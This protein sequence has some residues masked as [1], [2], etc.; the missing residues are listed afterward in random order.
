MKLIGESTKHMSS[1]VRKLS[2]MTDEAVFEE[3]A[4][5]ILREAKPEY[6]G[7]LHPGVNSTGKTVKSP[8]DGISFV[9]GATPSHMVAVHHTTCKR[10]GLQKKWLFDPATVTVRKGRRR[11]PTTPPGD[12]IKTAEIVDAERER[13]ATLLATLVLTTN[14]EPPEDVV[15]DAQAAGRLRGIEVDVWSVSRLAHFLDTTAKGQW[16]RDQYLGIAQE[17]LS[18]EL[19]AKLS[20]ESLEIHRPSDNPDAW[21]STVL[22]GRIA[23][24]LRKQEAVFIT[25]ESGLG[26][27][28][29]C[30]KR[31][32][33]HV[34][35]G[36]FGL[37]I[38]HQVINAALTI[39]QAVEA[40]LIQLH[41]KLAA[42]AGLDALSF[43]SAQQPLV[44]VIEDINRSGQGSL[45]L[46][47]LA[48]WAV[49]KAAATSGGPSTGG[50]DRDRWRLL[51]PI[52]PDVLASLGDTPRKHIQTLAAEGSVLTVPEGRE[53]VQRRGRLR[54][55]L[56]S[57]LD[58]DAVS[59]ALGHD[60]LLIALHE[61]TEQANPE[62]VIEQFIDS[63]VARS[64][65]KTG[66]YTAGEYRE[67]L[68]LIASGMLL[69]RT[70]QPSWSVLLRW[71]TGHKGAIPM[72]RQLVR[73]GEIIRIS[74][75]ASAESL[76]FRHDRVRDAL[77]SEAIAS[78][79]RS[80]T[81]T[82]D[83]LGEVYFAEV[84]GAAL[85]YKDIPE[86]VVDR[87]RQANPLALFH[88]LRLFRE[89][90]GA[91]HSAVLTA[92]ELWLSDPRTHDGQHSHLRWEA[93]AAMSRTE[94]T[95]V[96]GLVRKFKDSTWAAWQAL[97][98]N[99]DLAG[100]LNLCLTVEPGVTAIWRDRQVE[101]AKIHFGMQ[102]KTALDQLLRR[103]KLE[104]DARIGALRLSGY[105]GDPQLAESLEISWNHD[106]LKSDHLKDYLWACARCCGNNPDRFLGP[107]CDSWAA[108]PSQTDDNMPSPRDSLA[109]HEVR[110]AF[111]KDV[112]VSAIDYFIRRAACD[113]LRWPITYM[114]H[115][116]DYPS[117]VEFVIHELA[118]T[119]RRL[120]GS[121]SFS[122][123]SVSAT[124]DWRRRQ[125]DQGRPM[126]PE[127]RDRLLSL[128]QNQANDKH[129]RN[130][131]FRF[132][133][134]TEADGD[135]A[136][137]RSVSASD[138][139]AD[140]ALRYRL[141][142]KDR[143]GIP[144]LLLK[145]QDRDSSKR[146]YWWQQG[147]SIW[148]DDLTHALEQELAN[149]GT[150]VKR[151]WENEFATDY[152]TSQLI[153]ALP[154]DEAESMLV[155]HWEHLQF[156]SYFVQ[157]A[158]YVAT[159]SL[160]EKVA[161]VINTCSN[162]KQMLKYIDM[163]YGI[164]TKNRGGITDKKQ[165]EALLPYLDY[166]DDHT[167]YTFW[168]ACNDR[169]WI[170]LRR[171]GLDER[172]KGRR[173]RNLFIDD[174]QIVSSL[175]E[176]LGR[177][178]WIDHWIEEYLDS[179]ASPDVIMNVMRKWLASHMNLAALQLA[180]QAVIQVGRRHD[181]QILDVPIG[182]P[183]ARAAAALI[184]DT[185]FAVKR[186][187]LV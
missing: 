187:S 72:L 59:D 78:M 85:L 184:A 109:A 152:Q 180:A 51:C 103:P 115:G 130:Q 151:E 118:D 133:A 55:S 28:V 66:E 100:G 45:L 186:R 139:L 145:L 174:D 79:M 18:R 149:R 17:R 129:I 37:F 136:I 126:S 71:L 106:T 132:W 83:L 173:F 6:R 137:L 75:V 123:F 120:E 96:V 92:I 155:R 2:Q 23:E 113:D 110:W 147:H 159:P 10:D 82:G 41:P 107:V 67:A 135:V 58:A 122:P 157:A 105:L 91:V 179:G 127:S 169:G 35:A 22:D 11:R 87:V 94:S 69:H 95:Q 48:K 4:T 38:P 125:E 31:L 156:C 49:P 111:Q 168:E 144:D 124:D 74:G 40:A 70:L 5:A 34:S 176:M 162:P 76:A 93:L 148:S 64:V 119:D 140:S 52:W 7:L 112:P 24:H 26:K 19:L 56:L 43:C 1:T 165:V 20:R 12:L 161:N 30:Y 138:P 65:A 166:M 183:D 32:N 97:F 39:E 53:A 158:L 36:G 68:R 98:R 163:H 185:A 99:G 150:L 102:L 164:R 42:G 50:T 141:A 104:S 86:S 81:L 16:L 54:G 171:H 29:A 84:I 88:A 182:V 153:M 15:R 143:T 181:L 44:L 128:W 117:A 33:Q 178:H 154:R 108:L 172:L 146:A 73:H 134:S 13:N 121:K 142:R 46:E 167:I 25:A 63:S 77:L 14:Q 160:L 62:L 61:P 101:H 21:V 80:D 8:V 90:S 175:D 57:D 9:L 131:A 3:F 114:L 27:S 60:P 89:P 177:S 47:K 170:D 116:I